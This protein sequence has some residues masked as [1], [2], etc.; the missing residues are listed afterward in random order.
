LVRTTKNTAAMQRFASIDIGTNTALLL[1]AD[2]V[3]GKITKTIADEHAIPRLGEG[4]YIDGMIRPEAIQR[5][6]SVV[7]RYRTLIKG[8]SVYSAA[9]VATAALRNAANA[10]EI[11]GALQQA[12]GDIPLH[13]IDGHMEAELTYLGVV[14]SETKQCGV[15][16]V[17]GGSTELVWPTDTDKLQHISMEVGAVRLTDAWLRG[18]IPYGTVTMQLVPSSATEC[19]WFAV[20]GTPVALAVL[21]KELVQFDGDQLEG[22][23]LTL[24]RIQHWTKQLLERRLDSRQLNAIPEGRLDILPAGATILGS[25]ML[26]TNVPQI[27]VCTR[28]LRHGVLHA[29]QKRTSFTK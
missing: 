11:A 18:I 9:A 20:A 6:L 21:D 8:A 4:V 19:S 1:I 24:E 16:D 23:T 28:G 12:L 3:D 10:A 26:Q 14:G 7:E 5:V 15:I 17:G 29:L 25:L 27:T 2:V 22:Y 13:V